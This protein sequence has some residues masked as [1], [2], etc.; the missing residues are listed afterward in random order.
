[1][2]EL[3]A[4]PNIKSTGKRKIIEFKGYSNR[5]QI[6]DGE[7]REM[8]NL[9]SD[10]YP[11]LTQRQPRGYYYENNYYTHEYGTQKPDTLSVRN[12]ITNILSWKE[13][14]VVIAG[15]DLYY[16]NVKVA[17]LQ[18]TGDKK[19]CG[20]GNKLCVFPDKIYY[21]IE[22]GNLHKLESVH[23]IVDTNVMLYTDCIIITHL[24]TDSN[25]KVGDAVTINL[26]FKEKEKKYQRTVATII[27]GIMTNGEN[28]II[29]VNDNT[30]TNDENAFGMLN[31]EPRITIKKSEDNKPIN[32]INSGKY[33]KYVNGFM[34]RSV[35]DMDF[36]VENQNR[37]WGCKGSTIFSSKLG[38]P[39]N[40][41]YFTS[42]ITNNS[43]DSYAVSVGSDGDFTGC[44]SF[45]S[46][47]V[48]FKES[49]IHKLYGG[50][51][52]SSYQITTLECNGME[53]GS[54]KSGVTVDGVLYYKSPIG[55]MAYTGDYPVHITS[56]FKYRYVNAVAGSD[57]QK[58]YISM[59]NTATNE[60]EMFAF[61]FARKL[62]HKEDNAHAVEFAVLNGDLLY[63]DKKE[64][65]TGNLSDIR[66]IIA[67]SEEQIV[68]EDKKIPW[69]AVFGEFDEILEN[70]KIYSKLQLRLTMEKEAELSVWIATDESE[71]LLVA[72]LKNERKRSVYIPIIPRRC[73]KFKI[74][75]EGVG[76]TRIESLVRLVREG[77][78]V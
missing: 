14:L 76:R 4:L 61:D 21:D 17:T 7:M 69:Q 32:H 71:W 39:T 74:K 52:P 15:N 23:K 59:K 33:L 46:H 38:D 64:T 13:K 31:L 75:L 26:N 36:I 16:N 42:G 57:K 10:Q 35:P 68:K 30:F 62:W 70:K 63:L 5:P 41:N 44:V 8:Y 11:Y 27:K 34:K 2:P 50:N 67:P 37:L 58:Y 73:D 1:M 60:W 18:E 66:Y 72:N 40:F 43:A 25:F 24:S 53:K 51:K 28:T 6:S 3:V 9:S 77:S 56:S 29:M 19:I 48:F 78:E 12:D 49:Y 20:I 65:E 54:H 47:I 55:I 45:P 22:T